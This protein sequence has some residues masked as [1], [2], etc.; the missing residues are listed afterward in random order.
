MTEAAESAVASC[1]PDSFQASR[2][3]SALLEFYIKQK[4]KIKALSALD[5]LLSSDL[6]LYNPLTNWGTHM[7]LPSLGVAYNWAEIE[8]LD[9]SSLALKILN[10]ILEAQKKRLDDDNVQFVSTY[11]DI[12]T[13]EH[14]TGNDTAALDQYYQSIAAFSAGTTAKVGQ[15]KITLADILKS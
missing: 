3:R 12:A 11:N 6:K 7:E 14:L 15:I 9:D 13:V 5:L 8:T 10:K 1:G 2:Q 4:D